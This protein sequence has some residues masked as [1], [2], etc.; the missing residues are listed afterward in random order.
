M[1][2]DPQRIASIVTEVLERL[3]SRQPAP[4]GSGLAG[5]HPGLD[6]AVEAAR[7]AFKAYDQT[8]LESRRRIIAAAR[9]AL[10][11]QY[12]TLAALAVEETGLGRVEDK[13]QK[14]RLVTERTPETGD[15]R[16]VPM[17][18]WQVD[19]RGGL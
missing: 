1:A 18:A 13:V 3:E 5:V 14:N 19:E 6:R 8:P 16:P 12:G 10:S 9:E 11:S 7:A 17:K 15:E 4:G 2:L